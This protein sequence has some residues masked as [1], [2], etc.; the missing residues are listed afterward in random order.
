MYEL[1]CTDYTMR[2]LRKYRTLAGARRYV[3]RSQPQKWAIFHARPGFH[4]TTQTEYLVEQ[5]DPYYG[6]C[7][8]A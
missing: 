1:F 2:Y 7:K 3:R 8:R 5:N 6:D 4:S